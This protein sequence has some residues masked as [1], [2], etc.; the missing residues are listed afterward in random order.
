MQK[1]K[2]R[3]TLSALNCMLESATKMKN[4]IKA[5]LLLLFTIMT[6]SGCQ[7]FSQIKIQQADKSTTFQL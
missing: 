6:I 2:L 7:Q 5:L 1:E 4:R 3:T